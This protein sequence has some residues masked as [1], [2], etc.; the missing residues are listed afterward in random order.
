MGREGVSFDDTDDIFDDTDDVTVEDAEEKE[1]SKK[2]GSLD[3]RRMIE[4]RLEQRQ[5][6]KTIADYYDYDDWDKDD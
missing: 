4:D 3:K 1:L 2:T 5:L 6:K